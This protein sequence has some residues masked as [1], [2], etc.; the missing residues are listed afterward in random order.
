MS[1]AF[2]THIYDFSFRYKLLYGGYYQSAY[3]TTWMQLEVR[4]ARV[5]AKVIEQFQYCRNGKEKQVLCM[6][7]SYVSLAPAAKFTQF[8]EDNE[9][10]SVYITRFFSRNFES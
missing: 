4:S 3:K 10:K 6:F 9:D 5:C 7:F 8:M 2:F 1:C